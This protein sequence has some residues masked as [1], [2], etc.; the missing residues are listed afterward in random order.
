MESLAGAR[1][2]AGS[3]Q[4]D[5]GPGHHLRLPKRA[6]TKTFVRS[7]QGFQHTAAEITLQK[8]SVHRALIGTDQLQDL[9]LH[10]VGTLRSVRRNELLLR[11]KVSLLEK[12][13]RNSTRGVTE[14]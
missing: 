10:Y 4:S 13:N 1:T 11:R 9:R 5:F 7:G 8:I 3:T 12:G 6:T 2:A 14:L